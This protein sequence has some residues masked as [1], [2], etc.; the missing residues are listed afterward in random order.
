MQNHEI[1][2]LIRDH[3]L[4]LLDLVRQANKVIMTIRGEGE[5][6]TQFKSDQ[7]PVTKA[8]IAA[9]HVINQG[10]NDLFPSILVVSEEDS[11]SHNDRVNHSAYWLVDPLDGTK[12]F[13][14]GFD[15]FT[16][17]IALVV[18]DELGVGYTRFGVVSLPMRDTYY[19]GG[20]GI[21]SQKHRWVAG[22]WVSQSIAVGQP[23]A[24][25]RV[26]TSRSHLTQSTLDYVEGLNKTTTLVKAG[27]A[28]KLCLI[29]E[30]E[31]DLYPRLSP[32]CE[33]DIAAGHAVLEGAGGTV[34]HIDD[35]QVITYGDRSSIKLEGLIARG[36]H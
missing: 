26:V 8:D 25:L 15:D 5:L 27:S 9:H 3:H 13:I 22:S 24:P 35:K 6:N 33:W 10:L 21:E 16:V 36:I 1:N 11:R 32:I 30:G 12:E 34:R 2:S 20:L 19:S 14:N 31:A 18:R 29:A 17:N 23:Q 7:S 4:A 28:S